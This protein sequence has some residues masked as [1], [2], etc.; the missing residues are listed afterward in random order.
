MKYRTILFCL[1]ILLIT[2][3]VFAEQITE[4]A[5][6]KLC[7]NCNNWDEEHHSS[8]FVII[9]Y[10]V[11]SEEP[12][13]RSSV[14]KDIFN[15]NTNARSIIIL[16]SSLGKELASNMPLTLNYS[17][18]SHVVPLSFSTTK[19]I[20]KLVKKYR[21][22]KGFENVVKIPTAIPE[23]LELILSEVV[24][25]ESDSETRFFLHIKSHGSREFPLISLKKNRIQEMSKIQNKILGMKLDNFN[26]DLKL[27]NYGE[28]KLMNYI[29]LSAQN[30][31]S[32][33]GANE[34]SESGN[35]GNNKAILGA[36]EK[37]FSMAR[38]L[39]IFKKFEYKE[40]ILFLL[41]ESCGTKAVKT[42]LT[43]NSIVKY[44][45]DLPP[46]FFAKTKLAYNNFDWSKITHVSEDFSNIPSQTTVNQFNMYLLYFINKYLPSENLKVKS[47]KKL[48][49]TFP[50]EEFKQV[51]IGKTEI[52]A[53]NSYDNLTCLRPAYLTKEQPFNNLQNFRFVEIDSGVKYKQ[54]VGQCHLVSW[55]KGPNSGIK[56]L[57]Y[58]TCGLTSEG[59][60]RYWAS[61]ETITKSFHSGYKFQS[62][63]F[64]DSH[65]CGITLDGQLTCLGSNENGEINF[66]ISSSKNR[67][68]EDFDV[69][70]IL[71]D[72]TQLGKKNEFKAI[73]L[74]YHSSCVLTN[75][76]KVSCWGA[77]RVPPYM[78]FMGSL[79]IP[80][81]APP[82]FI[83]H[84]LAFKKI[85]KL[86]DRTCAISMSN[87]LWCW[88]ENK[89][90]ETVNQPELWI[91]DPVLVVQNQRFLD[92]ALGKATTCAIADDGK[93]SLWC[94]GKN[95]GVITENQQ[96]VQ[97]WAIEPVQVDP[98]ESYKQISVGENQLCGITTNNKL[99]CWGD[100]VGFF[101]KKEC[102]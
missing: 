9:Y 51:V 33:L 73:A 18:R 78:H 52:C 71:E 30:E 15:L 69:I 59:E 87:Q 80:E 82:Y 35:L 16:G 29:S 4:L 102:R 48:E 99:K 58:G 90:F 76:N 49:L 62:I 38:L 28:G 92:I 10:A 17:D 13:M 68:G 75:Q 66:E 12:F 23:V 27:S 41:L 11:D 7:S 72:L 97:S 53:I 60:V 61:N 89:N 25:A 91:K 64:G 50:S 43:E 5:N 19:N 86:E 98:G 36:S 8:N 65:F 101:C 96:A 24:A 6:I 39:E 67:N 57:D 54:L 55:D 14:D 79:A 37:L 20:I 94:W 32:H 74:G 84:E 95:K 42:Y 70:D 3:F 45:S 93:N 83:K 26:R 44:S 1:I 34:N 47:Q 31:Y 88:G 40:K 2:N 56:Q 46:F 22:I 85:A 63:A 21:K 77:D 81:G 100:L